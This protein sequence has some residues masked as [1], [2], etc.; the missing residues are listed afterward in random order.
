[1]K[2]EVT[3]S[4]ISWQPCYGEAESTS[5]SSVPRTRYFVLAKNNRSYEIPEEEFDFLQRTK[6]IR[7]PTLTGISHNGISPRTGA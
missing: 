7:G 3:Y 4:V 6:W 5:V 1:M 2:D